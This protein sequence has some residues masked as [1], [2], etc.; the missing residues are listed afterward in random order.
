MLALTRE[1]MDGR[2]TI[3]AKIG[4]TT[5]RFIIVYAEDGQVRVGIDAPEAV[6]IIREELLD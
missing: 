1:P 2:D 4:D 5:I 3:L 6:E